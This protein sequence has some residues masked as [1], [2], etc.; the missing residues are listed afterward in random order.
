MANSLHTKT[1]A[2]LVSVL[3]QARSEAGLTQQQLAE[4]LGKP[5]SFVAKIEGSERRLDVAEFVQ[6]ARAL[7]KS[8]IGLLQSYL[9]RLDQIETD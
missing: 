5:Q 3:L 2:S 7:N 6:Y 8:P 9:D 4:I 1:Y